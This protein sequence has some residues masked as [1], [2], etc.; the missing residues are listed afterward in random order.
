VIF[1][2][3]LRLETGSFAALGQAR[4]LVRPAAPLA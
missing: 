3:S 1:H 4:P 2:E